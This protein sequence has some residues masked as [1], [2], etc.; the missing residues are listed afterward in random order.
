MDARDRSECLYSYKKSLCV[1]L[2]SD[3]IRLRTR[4]SSSLERG[5]FAGVELKIPLENL[6]ANFEVV[7][8]NIAPRET[9][10]EFLEEV[11]ESFDLILEKAEDRGDSLET[12]DTDH[13]GGYLRISS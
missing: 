10:F 6:S 9:V 1:Y 13:L 4:S 7:D 5:F 2:G 11:A 12:I 3:S 8:V